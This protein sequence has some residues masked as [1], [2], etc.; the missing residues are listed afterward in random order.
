FLQGS[1]LEAAALR[2][3]GMDS[4][5]DRLELWLDHEDRDLINEKLCAHGITEDD[6]IIA[7]APGAGAAKRLWPVEK[8]V[9]VGRGLQREYSARVV[10]I[11]GVEDRGSCERM[12]KELGTEAMNFAGALS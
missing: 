10:L 11:G 12:Q 9:E 3:A 5:N 8:F 2:R 7:I 1:L 4:V 6:M